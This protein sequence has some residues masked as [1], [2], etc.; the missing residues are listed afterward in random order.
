M[1]HLRLEELVGMY[2]TLHYMVFWLFN[3]L[4]NDLPAYHHE[5]TI[6]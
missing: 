3:S 2:H 4:I 5:N 1:P 6:I